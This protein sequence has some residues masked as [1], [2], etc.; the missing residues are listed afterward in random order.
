MAM[1]EDVGLRHR[2]RTT[3]PARTQEQEGGRRRSRTKRFASQIA[4]CGLRLADSAFG[5]QRVD[6][7][8]DV[9]AFS[10][11]FRG[12]NGDRAVRFLPDTY[13][14]ALRKAHREHKFLLVYLHAHEHEDVPTFVENTLADAVFASFV[15]E[16]FVCWGGDVRTTEANK[17]SWSLGATAYPFMALLMSH[18][19][20]RT[21][22]ILKQKGIC[23][24][25][26]MLDMLVRANEEQGAMLV[27]LRAEEEERM[28]NRQL[29]EE[30]DA[31]YL[32][33]LE[34]DRKREEELEE[35]QRREEEET[36][37]VQEE[38]ERIRAE[39]LEEERRIQEKAKERERIRAEKAKKS[40]ARARGWSWNYFHS[41]QAT[42]WIAQT[43]QVPCHCHRG[44][45]VRLCGFS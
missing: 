28:R 21:S 20:T 45:A 40:H 17:L 4:A 24:K 25:E 22:V 15:S 34:A 6:A 39:Q 12:K 31:A 38:E 8:H 9:E 3:S 29:R 33:S 19:S 36:R 32:A 13:R 7:K 1:D 44:A 35:A 37:R 14:E 42:R 23:E 30:Q 16:N 2:R 43:S 41:N 18:S 10:R 11:E 27:A 5:V 26:T